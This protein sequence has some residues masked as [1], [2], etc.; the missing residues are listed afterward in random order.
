MR[1]ESDIVKTTVALIALVGAF[2][3]GLWL[4]R[5]REAADLQER[6]AAREKQIATDEQGAQG[7]EDLRQAVEDLSRKATQV[8]HTV[9]TRTDMAELLRG[10]GTQ[11]A[12]AKL[13]EQEVQ[14]ESVVAGADYQ[15]IPLSLRCRGPFGGVYDFIHSL[16]S[17]PRLIRCSRLTLSGSPA[18]PEEPLTVRL[19]MATFAAVEKATP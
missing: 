9:P 19:E 13:T 7:I 2:V 11:I 12:L 18:K 10:I 1:I 16:E 4:P 5:H 3:G 14:T 6:I 8:N 17:G 15:M